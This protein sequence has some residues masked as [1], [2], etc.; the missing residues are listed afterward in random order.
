M[1]WKVSAFQFIKGDLSSIE[2]LRQAFQ[3]IDAVVHT[4]ALSSTWGPWRPSIW[5]NVVGT[6]NVL[7]LC[8]EY[9]VKRLVLRFF[10]SIYAAGKKTNLTSRESD[11]PKKIT[12]TITSEANWRLKNFF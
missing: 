10:S 8:R 6:Q 9:A 2:E 12:S 5:Q 11:A 4:G 3:S 1:L 7:D